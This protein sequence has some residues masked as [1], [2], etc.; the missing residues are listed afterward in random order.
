MSIEPVIVE[1]EVPLAP[2][3]AFELFVGGLAT[4]WP[5]EYTW[6]GEVL[7]T[8]AI[9]PKVGGRC[10]ELGPHGFHCDWGRVVEYNPP[11]RIAFTWQIGAQREPLPDPA[12]ASMVTVTFDSHGSR[13]VVRL[14]HS[15]F[16]RHRDGDNYREMLASPQGWP[17]IVD[18]YAAAAGRRS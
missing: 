1:V 3:E 5:R 7:E 18:R 17:L 10:Y 4:W 9:E 12:A 16:E 2:P 8:I 6:S 14:E 13:T 11:A 15:G